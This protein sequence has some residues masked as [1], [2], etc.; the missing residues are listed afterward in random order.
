MATA[1]QSINQ[2]VATQPSAAPIL[3]RFEIDLCSHANQSLN[4]A[5]ADLQLS[6]EQVLEKLAAAEADETGAPTVD[7]STMSPQKLIQH[8]VRLHHRSVRQQLPPLV[9][10]ARELASTCADHATQ[11]EI[12]QLADKLQ[13]ELIA[14]IE[15]EENI[16][17]P[18]IAYLDQPAETTAPT[19]SKC[20]RGVSQPVRMMMQD[21]ASTER[22]LAELKRFTTCLHLPASAVATRDSFSD[23]LRSFEEDLQLHIRLEDEILFPR[24]IELEEQVASLG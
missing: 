3:K 20:F 21:H 23:G 4:E 13:G 10:L 2:I 8:I 24:A 7:P 18:Y 22:I 16:L 17:F 19:G 12:E 5:C 1:T 6:V 15:K 14:H 9:A 11:R